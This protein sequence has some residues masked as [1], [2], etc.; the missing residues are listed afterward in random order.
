ML[1]LWTCQKYLM[2]GEV[3]HR[4]KSHASELVKTPYKVLRVCL[5][6]KVFL[7]ALHCEAPRED[8]ARSCQ[9]LNI[10]GLHVLQKFGKSHF[11]GTRFWRQL[12]PTRIQLG[13]NHTL[14]EQSTREKTETYKSIR[15]ESA[16]IQ[17]LNAKKIQSL[18]CWQ[19]GA[20]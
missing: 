11:L 3:V 19:L 14:Q 9:L 17:E 16:C 8:I 13:R 12:C 1:L 4:K 15:R 7:V 2:L 6:R 20:W 10:P 18:Q 5:V